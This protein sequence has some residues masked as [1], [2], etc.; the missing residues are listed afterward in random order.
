MTIKLITYLVSLILAVPRYVLINTDVRVLPI[1]NRYGLVT[2][3]AHWNVYIL[4]MYV[5]NHLIHVH[6]HLIHVHTHL[7]HVHTHL[8]HVHVCT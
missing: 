5:H 3:W 7:I 8:I 4:R 1:L 2:Q 6:T